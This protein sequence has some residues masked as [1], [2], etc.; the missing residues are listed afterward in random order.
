[1]NVLPIQ[2]TE[3]EI[4]IPREYLPD[5]DELELVFEQDYVIVR[6][7]VIES[8]LADVKKRFPWIGMGR[9]GNPN[10]SIEA[11]EVLSRELHRRSGWTHKPPLED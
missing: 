5:S 8:P 11:E 1:M 9:S 3:K 7:K 10:A 2:V 6:L 4:R